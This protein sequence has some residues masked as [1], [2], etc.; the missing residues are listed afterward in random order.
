MS[1]SDAIFYLDHVNGSDA[2]RATLSGVVFSNPSGTIVRGA[3]AGHGLVTGAIVTVSGTTNWNGAW[4]ITKVDDNN[5]DL[6]GAVWTAGAD[7][8]GDV[9]PFGGSSWA[10]AWKTITAGAT[11]AR[12]AAGDVVRIAKSPAP[13]SLGQTAKWTDTTKVGGGL[14]SEK[15]ISS[16]TDANPISV[17]LTGHGYSSGDV[18]SIYGHSTNYNAN[19][20]WVIT[21]TDANNF[22]LTGAIGNGAGA[23]GATGKC[24]RVNSRT[25][26]LSTAVTLMI[27]EADGGWT[28]SGSSTVSHPAYTSDGKSGNA[29]VKVVKFSPTANTLYAYKTIPSTDFSSYGAITL[30]IKVG[31]AISSTDNWKICLCANADGTG[32]LDTFP[33]P[34]IAGTGEWKP[35]RIVKSGG[36]SLNSAVGSIALYS[37][38]TAA[39][40]SGISMD[41]INACSATG[42]NLASLIS[43]SSAEHGGD[44]AFYGLKYIAGR[45]LGL[46]NEVASYFHQGNGY[47][48]T[49]ETVTLYYR[50]AV[51]IETQEALQDSGTEGNLIEFLGGYNT[52]NN[53]QDGETYL[54]FMGYS[55]GY[56]NALN[57]S[58]FKLDRLSV[59]R[60]GLYGISIQGILLGAVIGEIND[61]NN[62][63]GHGLY[64]GTPVAI[65]TLKHC[66]N[67]G[68]FGFYCGG[69]SVEIT[70]ISQV[71][72]NLLHGISIAG[73]PANVKIS[74]I[75]SASNNG[76]SSRYRG[77]HIKTS[78]Y[79]EIG[80]ISEASLNMGDGVAIEETCGS[81]IE[82]VTAANF[83]G[84]N[85][86]YF[87][88]ETTNNEI[89]QI[90]A[91]NGNGAYG[92]AY[93]ITALENFVNSL[94][95]QDNVTGAISNLGGKQYIGSA[96]LAE[97]TKISNTSN[98]RECFV[99]IARYGVD[100][101][102]YRGYPNG[103]A[104]DQI[105]GGQTEA[106]AYGGSGLCQYYN[107]SSATVPI[108]EEFYIPCTANTAIQCHFYKRKTVSGA[109]CKVSFSASGCGITPIRNVDVNLS[110]AWSE[111]TSASM[112]PTRTGF[113]RIVLKVYD[114]TTTGDIGIDDIHAAA[115]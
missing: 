5:F 63:S 75:G 86:I 73:I 3:Y 39:T 85:G 44:E 55:S 30:W 50:E 94:S 59:T 4:K 28:A 102:W 92:V 100:G 22:T 82:T 29:C 97:S 18:V 54:D 49:T 105:T 62:C 68:S 37:G 108:V 13:V 2:V 16:T 1:Y 71:N 48:G 99:G 87:S 33:L 24:R 52:S 58:Y 106:W 109:T 57:R 9:V 67:N 95:T 7:N 78:G 111:F 23:G 89:N 19:G 104:S 14:E 31:T 69:S 51:Q 8:T 88:S 42:L 107:P 41:N 93:A 21:V 36:G 15:S 98:G 38:G 34:A 80:T 83:N 27:D 32:I 10:D 35:F 91:A 45:C 64:I 74:T 11:A 96:S 53:V 114:G 17:A 61:L 65:T 77:I 76:I 101:R 79:V 110:D 43:K 72:N 113:I 70:T 26:L 6:D 47:H 46:D 12:I 56:I 112:T 20:T 115:V 25:V 60:G 84:V 81:L 103:V 66:N 90:T 40:T